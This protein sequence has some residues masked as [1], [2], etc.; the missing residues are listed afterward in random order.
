[1]ATKAERRKQKQ[2][3]KRQARKDQQRRPAERSRPKAPALPAIQSPDARRI[4]K[5]QPRAWEGELPEDVAVFDDAALESLPADAAAH[6]AAVRAGLA[7]AC[8]GR[9]ERALERVA[10]VPRSSKASEWNL[11]VRGLVA[12]LADDVE[13]AE[14]AWRRLDPRR[15]PGRI[16]VAMANARR[17]DLKNL[18]VTSDDRSEPSDWRERL[19]GML[20]HHAKLLR[21]V[22]FDR[23]AIRIA[24][25]GVNAPEEDADSLLGPAKLDWLRHFADEY[26]A[27][28][29]ALVS[30]LGQVALG[31]AFA[32]DEPDLFDAAVQVFPGPRHDPRSRLLTYFYH[33]DFDQESASRRAAERALADYLADDLPNNEDLSG[34]LRQALASEIHRNQAGLMM[35]ASGMATFGRD[36]SRPADQV[37]MRRHLERAAALYPTNRLAYSNHADWLEDGLED[38]TL[39]KTD[40]EPLL[41]R[42]A[43]VMQHWTQGLPG[44]VRPRRW[45]CE[46][47]MAAERMEEA[48]PHVDWL[49]A[50]RQDDPLVRS[51]PWRWH[52]FEAMRLSRRKG[53]IDEARIR[54][55]EAERLWPA[56]LSRRWLPYLRAALLLREGRGEEFERHRRG[57]CDAASRPRD[58]L[59]D[60]CMT[61]AAA[62]RMR[63]PAADLKPLRQPVD[64]AV[65]RIGRITLDGLL[66]AAQ[67]FWDLHR[68]EMSYP[69]YRFHGSKLADELGTRLADRPDLAWDRAEDA[70]LHAALLWLSEHRVWSDGYQMRL[71]AWFGDD[72]VARQPMFVAAKV[73]TFLRQRIHWDAADHAQ[74]APLLREAAAGQSDAYYRHW[75]G[76]LAENLEE[77][78]RKT[79]ADRLG[80]ERFAEAFGGTDGAEDDPP[81][82]DCADCRAGRR[83]AQM[84]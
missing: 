41:D 31:R 54:L 29:P 16:A 82:C 32:Q 84:P 67:F 22:R 66:S 69:A 42:L 59:A 17:D 47:L 43:Q 53:R 38:E 49:S 58:S 78:V 18:G 57:I 81:D 56:W 64:A 3:Q 27:T 11:F 70:R 28:E 15:R 35:Q 23:T 65:A 14:R 40:R 75:L 20:L 44:D 13:S 62:Q 72:R 30:A 9:G 52:L 24:E 60:A 6:V 12:W 34:P 26:R 63:V 7:D 2:K 8:A 36:P 19:D 83:A 80:L 55:E 48:R 5:Q 33:R 46:R 79:A 10:R 4:A 1:M 45:L 25:A 61:L 73:S 39:T 21:R 71:P 77:V 76:E 51:A 50:A 37:A 68:T 74:A